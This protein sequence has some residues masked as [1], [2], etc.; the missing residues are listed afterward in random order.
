[1]KIFVIGLHKTGTTSLHLAFLHL[2]YRS[3]HFFE[4]TPLPENVDCFSDMPIPL[5]FEALDRQFPG[6]KF[7]YTWRERESWLESC[8]RWFVWNEF[9]ERPVVYQRVKECYGTTVFDRE[10]FA[11]VYDRHHERVMAYFRNRPRDFLKLDFPGDWAW[12]PLCSFLGKPIPQGIP[13]PHANSYQP[14][15]PEIVE[16]LHTIQKLFNVP[17]SELGHIE[18]VE[19]SIYWNQQGKIAELID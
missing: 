11:A 18:R 9:P 10:R 7:I 3:R 17:I 15:R 5:M 13:F 4:S 14:V 19:E 1:M 2:G 8:S 6:S 16:T 12:E